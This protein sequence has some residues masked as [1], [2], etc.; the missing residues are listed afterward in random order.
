[1]DYNFKQY[2]TLGKSRTI[3]CVHIAIL[4]TLKL[5]NS[6]SV[7]EGIGLAPLPNINN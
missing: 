7:I 6:F 5:Q 3:I 1:M 2:G 4:D